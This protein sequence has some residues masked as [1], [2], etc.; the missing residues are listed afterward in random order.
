MFPEVK[1]AGNSAAK[2][3]D[4]ACIPAKPRRQSMLEKRHSRLSQGA[5]LGGAHADARMHDTI[6]PVLIAGSMGVGYDLSSRVDM[7]EGRLPPD[8]GKRRAARG[9]MRG[10]AERG[11]GSFASKKRYERSI[12][13]LP[14]IRSPPPKPLAIGSAGVLPGIVTQLLEQE[15]KKSDP[16]YQY[17]QQVKRRQQA[18]QAFESWVRTKKKSERERCLKRLNGN[19]GRRAP[20]VSTN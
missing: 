4:E 20:S 15:R 1:G 10:Y 9:S 12:H 14:D 17:R 7:E 2:S 11:G 13:D 5:V 8:A 16:I 3:G 19:V 6:E 18:H